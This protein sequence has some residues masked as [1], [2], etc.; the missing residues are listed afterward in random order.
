MQCVRPSR[1]PFTVGLRIFYHG[2]CRRQE[3]TGRPVTPLIGVCPVNSGAESYAPHTPFDGDGNTMGTNACCLSRFGG[4]AMRHGGGERFE[5]LSVR[6]REVLCLIA[7][8]YTNQEIAQKLFISP[9][10]VK[11]H[12]SRIYQK[13]GMDDRTKVALWAVRRGLVSLDADDTEA[14]QRGDGA[15]EA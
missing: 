15:D 5:E 6:E 10:T 9:H 1:P 4:L 3:A 12:V 14:E 11:N 13:I 7:K 2:T 8:G